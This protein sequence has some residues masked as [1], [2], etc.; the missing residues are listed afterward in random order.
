MQ[1]NSFDNRRRIYVLTFLQ[2]AK[3]VRDQ[4]ES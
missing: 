3:V 1:S 4:E 2:K